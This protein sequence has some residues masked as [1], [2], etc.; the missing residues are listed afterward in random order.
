M[1]LKEK[2][3]DEKVNRALEKVS[4]RKM[5]I[6]TL[7]RSYAAHMRDTM[8]EDERIAAA[9]KMGHSSSQNK[10]YAPSS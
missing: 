1:P 3:I 9:H 5:T 2:S 10:L 6:N 4:G 8:D 7:R